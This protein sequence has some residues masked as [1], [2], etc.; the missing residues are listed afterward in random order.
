M[1][2]WLKD[3]T[4]LSC[5]SNVTTLLLGVAG[6]L[7][8]MLPE[9]AKRIEASK[10]G[11][12][13][14]AGVFVMLAAVAIASGLSSA[15][16]A[17]VQAEADKNEL[18]DQYTAL[19]TRFTTLQLA[20][21][22]QHRDEASQYNTLLQRPVIN[23]VVPTMQP[24]QAVPTASAPIISVAIECEYSKWYNA[25]TT[26]VL[27]SFQ[28][29]VSFGSYGRAKWSHQ[30]QPWNVLDC[31]LYNDSTVDIHNVKLGVGYAYM[32][33]QPSQQA[34][35][36]HFINI[37]APTIQRIESGKTFRIGVMSNLT[38]MVDVSPRTTCSFEVATAHGQRP[39]PCSL[40]P[41]ENFI[42]GYTEAPSPVAPIN[43][44]LIGKD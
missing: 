2:G 25:D 22:K 43:I 6:V 31:E 37:P 42:P 29:A 13:V 27:M 8:A 7:L 36:L 10:I 23:V 35:G 20:V 9:N 34:R 18:K 5:I 44:A 4:V 11:R 1:A 38:A 16:F 21:N 26:W 28:T 14:L 19:N 3:P 17:S 15:H 39:A 41:H 24:A 30:I 40:I 32:P 33:T 12:F